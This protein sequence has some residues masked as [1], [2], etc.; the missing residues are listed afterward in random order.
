MKGDF[1]SAN[2]C[3]RDGNYFAARMRLPVPLLGLP[4]QAL[5]YT[6]WAALERPDFEAYFDAVR[7][8]AQKQGARALARLIN[9]IAG[10]P[11][12]FGLMG[13]AF[14]QTDGGGPY[15]LLDPKQPDGRDN[16]PLAIEQRQGASLDRILELY[17]GQNHEM[18]A[19]LPTA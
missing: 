7:T 11:D 12:T 10:F 3:V 16:H 2:F 8:N 6:V 14:Q 9:R 19:S 15:L 5:M 13:M 1:L 17:A 4:G 18:R